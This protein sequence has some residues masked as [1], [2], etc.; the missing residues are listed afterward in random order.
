M[1]DRTDHRSPAEAVPERGSGR[2]PLSVLDLVPRSEGMAPADAI[3]AS[4]TY[5]QRLDDLG[6]HRLWVAE[7]HN[8]TTFMS[9]ATALLIG[10]LGQGTQ[11]IRLGS[12][13]VMLPNHS[14][15]M[16]AEYYGTLATLFP[17]RIDLGMGRAPGTDPMTAAA[18]ARRSAEL[19]DIAH[20][21]AQLA[22]WFGDEPEAAVGQVRAVPG[23]GT[24]VPLWMLGSSTGG[25][26]V[27]A[28]LGLPFSFASHFA[29]AQLEQALEVYRR[30]F[31]PDAPTAQ[32][33]RPHVMAGMNA[34]V[35][36]T[37]EE[38]RYLFTTSQQLAAGI[39]SGRPAPL[40]PPVEDID[41]VVPQDLL[42]LADGHGIR[43]VGDPQQ[44]TERLEAFVDRY[45]LDEVI[46]TTYTHD[47]AMRV[48]S[49]ELLADAWGL[50]QV[51]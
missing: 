42:Q 48:R 39:R 19:Q 46:T 37:E 44:V 50:P 5:A 16:V 35:A 27:A 17:D 10:H 14:P 1:S 9:S 8:T 28:A 12:G 13:G 2:V 45:Q 21:V 23:G 7:H 6:Y 34:L 41:R 47:P 32:V 20:D 26:M 38:A 40:Q 18:L 33:D 25:A 11:R 49:A 29:P 24:G 51:G 43:M 3:E 36:P 15:L 4:R 31:D 22:Q 30:Q